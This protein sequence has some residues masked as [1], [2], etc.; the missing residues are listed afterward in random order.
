MENIAVQQIQK[1]LSN[2]AVNSVGK[3]MPYLVYEKKISPELS[4]A[5]T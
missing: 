1:F 4:E 5:L 2:I 3:S